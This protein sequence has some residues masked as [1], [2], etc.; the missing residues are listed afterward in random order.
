MTAASATIASARSRAFRTSKGELEGNSPGSA[1]SSSRCNRRT[2]AA[3]GVGGP[4]DRT[5]PPRTAGTTSSSPWS[6]SPP[7]RSSSNM[8]AAGG[9]GSSRRAS[10][11]SGGR[12][13]GRGPPS[14]ARN[15][16]TIPP[17]TTGCPLEE[18]CLDLE[19]VASGF[20]QD[21]VLLEDFLHVERGHGRL[22]LLRPA[23]AAEGPDSGMHEAEHDQLGDEV[24][25]AALVSGTIPVLRHSSRY[26]V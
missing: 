21:L 7:C 13:G 18:G 25:H 1:S 9:R 24:R 2:R 11:R 22:D 20:G 19:A 26:V 3:R 17:R 23:A 8:R 6:S 14:R 10:R 16:S 12:G 5:G 4:Q 15:S